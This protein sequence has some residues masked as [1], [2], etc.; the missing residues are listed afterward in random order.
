MDK[1]Y[2]NIDD[3]IGELLIER[4]KA[5]KHEVTEIINDGG[6][7]RFKIEGITGLYPYHWVRIGQEIFPQKW[8]MRLLFGLEYPDRIRFHQQL[9][10]KFFK[11]FGF[12]TGAFPK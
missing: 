11:Q 6:K 4:I 10:D 9:A 8:A 12:E 1:I 5:R 7:K 2:T 3:W